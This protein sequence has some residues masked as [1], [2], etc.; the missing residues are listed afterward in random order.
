MRTSK[1]QGAKGHRAGRLLGSGDESPLFDRGDRRAAPSA[2][3][4]IAAEF[5]VGGAQI[6]PHRL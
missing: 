5:L 4:E 2:Q 3:L 6:A 1:V